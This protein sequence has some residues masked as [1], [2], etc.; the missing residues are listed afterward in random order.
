[1]CRLILMVLLHRFWRRWCVWPISRRWLLHFSFNRLVPI[2]TYKYCLRVQS[3][4][5]IIL[6]NGWSECTWR[7]KKKLV[8]GDVLMVLKHMVSLKSVSRTWLGITA[9]I[10]HLVFDISY[11]TLNKCLARSLIVGCTTG[12]QFSCKIVWC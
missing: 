1:M 2:I 8:Y 3:C 5:F 9:V 12:P 10:L 4:N 7:Y 11:T 6:D